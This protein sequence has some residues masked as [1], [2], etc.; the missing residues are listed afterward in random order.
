MAAGLGFPP[1]YECLLLRHLRKI[2]L[3][4]HL[5]PLLPGIN[6]IVFFCSN[7]KKF[8]YS[9]ICRIFEPEKVLLPSSI[10]TQKQKYSTV[11]RLF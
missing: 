1:P 7:G 3:L 5:P 10:V 2:Y 4:Q 9:T 6:T 8:T 11:R